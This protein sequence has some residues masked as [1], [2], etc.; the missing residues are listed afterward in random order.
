LQGGIGTDAAGDV[1][2]VLDFDDMEW[3]TLEAQLAHEQWPGL[4]GKIGSA[5][6]LREVRRL[7]MSSLR[8]FNHVWV[9][10]EEDESLLPNDCP[11]HSVLP[12][13]PYAQDEFVAKE[14]IEGEV[15]F[16]GDLQ[17]PSNRDGLEKFLAH[18][19]PHVREAVPNSILRIVGRG[20]SDEQRQRWSK[21][22]GV[23]VIGFAPDLAACYERAALCV[24]P[25]FFGGGTKIK[26]L[27][28]LLHER[29]VVTTEHAL[30]GYGALNADGPVALAA[31]DI[32][33]VAEG[34]IMLLRDPQRRK[35]MAARGRVI[36]SRAFSFERFQGVVDSALSPLLKLP[37]QEQSA[38]PA[39]LVP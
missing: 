4:K 15:L 7:C 27:E 29:A 8:L 9:T 3:Q 16:V 33:G 28:A 34:C 36:V 22:D 30:R 13:I 38:A 19:W 26:V 25:V 20:L 21:L 39:A 37:V 35:E 11:P 31:L 10:S 14:S 18:A 23:D 5:M 2:A 1:P 12:N 17:L 6:A 32:A 24:V